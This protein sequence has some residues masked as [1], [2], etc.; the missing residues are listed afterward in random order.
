MKDDRG[1]PI[2]P[3]PW[4]IIAKELSVEWDPV[5]ITQLVEELNRSFDKEPGKRRSAEGAPIHI[6]RPTF[7]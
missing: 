5:K 1:S 6:S 2:P 7:K 4:R 3:R